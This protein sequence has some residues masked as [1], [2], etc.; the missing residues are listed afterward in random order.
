[1]FLTSQISS[2]RAG[3]I[4]L[5]VSFV[6]GALG[7]AGATLIAG[8]SLRSLDRV[9]YRLAEAR[10]LVNLRPMLGEWPLRMGGWAMDALFAELIVFSIL[11]TQPRLV[12][13]CGSGSSTVL[14]AQCLRQLGGGL[15]IALEHDE[16]FAA[17]TRARLL[18]HDLLSCARV[19]SAPLQAQSVN[20][21]HIA[22]YSKVPEQD[23]VVG[24]DLLVVD[25][26]PGG[27]GHRARYPA[28][29]LLGK[30]LSPTCTI[31]LDDGDRS[32]E[33]WIAHKWAEELRGE[34]QYVPGG[35]G[36]W[37][38]R[39]SLDKLSRENAGAPSEDSVARRRKPL[40]ATRA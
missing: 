24:I 14:I 18:A 10:A 6:I 9:Q 11:E 25:G 2:H 28:V 20:G 17:Q 35:R 31:L 19:V 12:V 36:A 39:R 40:G 16:R 1:M 34:L 38:I 30:H 13:E 4:S 26:P 8:L 15:V 23:L 7:S 37:T 33:R 5:W 21:S 22:W 32:D 29:P 27:S 3:P